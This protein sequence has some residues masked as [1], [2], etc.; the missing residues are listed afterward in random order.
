MAMK[1]DSRRT[2][3]RLEIELTGAIFTN[4]VLS[5]SLRNVRHF[6]SLRERNCYD[7]RDEHWR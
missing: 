4:E 2:Q 1:R 7:F 6:P 3:G 5:S